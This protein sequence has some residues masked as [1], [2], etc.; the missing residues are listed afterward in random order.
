MVIFSGESRWQIA[1]ALFGGVIGLV[2]MMSAV[3]LWFDLRALNEGSSGEERFVMVNKQVSLLNTFGV[4]SGF[5]ED[6]LEDIIGQPFVENVSPLTSNQFRVTAYSPQLGFSTE[7]FF[8]SLPARYLDLKDPM[9][10]SWREGDARLPIVLSRDYLALYNFG[11]APAQGLPQF[12][13]G[14]IQRVSFDVI[15]EGNGKRKVFKGYIAGFSDRVN[16]VLVPEEFMTWANAAY[17]SQEFVRPSRLMVEA[18]NPWSEE[19][20][21]YLSEN[22]L[23]VGRGKLIGGQVALAMSLGIGFIGALGLSLVAVAGI[24]VLLVFELMVSK[25][26]AR[27]RLLLELGYRSSRISALISERLLWLMAL[28]AILAG[29]G[30][31]VLRFLQ[32]GWMAAQGM[33]AAAL[34]NGWSFGAGFA[35]V[36]VLAIVNLVRIRHLVNR[37]VVPAV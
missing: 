9:G 29:V 18:E 33:N 16:S 14:T 1:V 22:G 34:P 20:Q 26:S 37:L 35:V 8:E 2:L 19:F 32:A 7:L 24:G 25:A 6:E 23:E 13:A 15:V 28:M 27:I 31:G 36:A 5:N 21:A 11:F 4:A 10:F 3:E 12:T 17:G 30:V